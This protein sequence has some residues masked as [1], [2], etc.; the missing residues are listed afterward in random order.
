MEKMEQSPLVVQ[1][2]IDDELCFVLVNGHSIYV[3]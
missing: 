3:R 2:M 1:V